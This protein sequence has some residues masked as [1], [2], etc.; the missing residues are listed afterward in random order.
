VEK[1]SPRMVHEALGPGA[2][3]R[4]GGDQVGSSRSDRIRFARS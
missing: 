3:L 1:L 2:P 4:G